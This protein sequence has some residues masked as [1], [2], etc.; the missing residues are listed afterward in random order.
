MNTILT[1]AALGFIGTAL[2]YTAGV[3]GGF[4]GALLLIG[5]ATF[6]TVAGF[7]V[8]SECYYNGMRD[9]QEEGDIYD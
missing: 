6:I 2:A 9:A 1:S 8:C 4:V 7:T 5:A 3:L